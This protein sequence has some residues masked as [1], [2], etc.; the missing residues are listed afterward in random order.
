MEWKLFIG[1]AVA[2][3]ELKKTCRNGRVN[4]GRIARW[5][6]VWDDANVGQRDPP[7]D[8]HQ[9]AGNFLGFKVSEGS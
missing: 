1:R 8:L 9:T 4:G 2:L 3:G 6:K 7:R 5:M